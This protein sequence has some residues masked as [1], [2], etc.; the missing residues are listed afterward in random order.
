MT[1]II[2]LISIKVENNMN[3]KFSSS[4][5]FL[6][7]NRFQVRM[8]VKKQSQV[9]KNSKVKTQYLESV[10]N[11]KDKNISPNKTFL[12]YFSKYFFK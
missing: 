6:R 4:F 10:L 9:S 5:G 3:L 7:G 11:G 12:I 1:S 2:M 8:L